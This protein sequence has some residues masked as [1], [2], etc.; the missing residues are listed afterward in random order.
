MALDA[1]IIRIVRRDL[2]FDFDMVSGG[3]VFVTP[4]QKPLLC[5][6]LLNLNCRCDRYLHNTDQ[7]CVVIIIVQVCDENEMMCRTVCHQR[8]Y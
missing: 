2:H 7:L 5:L 8:T 4:Q 1:V 6:L 3:N